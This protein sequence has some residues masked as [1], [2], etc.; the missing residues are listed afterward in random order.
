[1]FNYNFSVSN[2]NKYNPMLNNHILVWSVA[3][4]GI[5]TGTCDRRTGSSLLG[6]NTD[7]CKK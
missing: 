6:K 1:M 5:A 4:H 2:P 7:Y 3:N